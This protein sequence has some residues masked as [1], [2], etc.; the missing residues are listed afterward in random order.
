MEPETVT[1]IER[2]LRALADGQVRF[3]VIGGV[4]AT[5]HGSA[6]PTFDLDVVYD[7]APENIARLVAALAPYQPYLRGVPRGLPFSWDART[8]AAGL[9]FT[10]T[11]T[12]GSLDVLGEVV[13]GGGYEELNLHTAIVKPFGIECRCLDLETL[14]RVKRA[15]GRNKDLLALAELEV[16]RDELR[17]PQ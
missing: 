12:L 14:I 2:L 6:R 13:G 3:I 4:A 10:L 9:N 7:R 15:A 11:T 16:L 1:D 5:I 8:I 17:R